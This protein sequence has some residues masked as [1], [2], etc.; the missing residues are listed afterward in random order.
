[1]TELNTVK[2]SRHLT[3]SSYRR[4]HEDRR[5][6]MPKGYSLHAALNLKGDWLEAA[7]FKTH[8][9]VQLSVEQGKIVIELMNENSA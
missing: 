1:M 5:T 3:V 9:R 6:K 2:P 7:G 8:S 4:R